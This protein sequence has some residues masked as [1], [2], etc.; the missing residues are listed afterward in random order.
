MERITLEREVGERVVAAL[1]ASAD[2]QSLT[3]GAV[4]AFHSKQPVSGP[5]VALG[6]Y[7]T[8]YAR[9]K[10]GSYADSFTFAVT[11][12]AESLTV[13]ERLEAAC[14]AAVD[15]LEI[16]ALDTEVQLMESTTDSDGTDM[17]CKLIFEIEL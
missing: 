1:S 15:G 6:N 11:C 16:P 3:K 9:T 14:V 13:V 10:D 17:F 4:F 5:F 8:G 12:V 7:R 2:V